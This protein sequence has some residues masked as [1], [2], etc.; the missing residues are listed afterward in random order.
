MIERASS[1][2]TWKLEHWD[3]Y[4][5]RCNF[6]MPTDIGEVHVFKNNDG[7]EFDQSL[8]DIAKLLN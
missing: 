6:N 8:E 1:R 7:A 3:E 4:I 2:D 5:S